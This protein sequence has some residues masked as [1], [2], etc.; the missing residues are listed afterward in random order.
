LL[1]GI[2]GALALV[3]FPCLAVLINRL[4]E[5]PLPPAGIAAMMLLTPLMM[6][7]VHG[8]TMAKFDPL[9]ATGELPVYIAV[10][11]MTNGGF[12][13]A[14]LV[15]ALATSALTWLIT[16]FGMGLVV[17]LFGTGTAFSKVDTTSP[18]GLGA[19]LIGCVPIFLLLVI[20]TWKNLI[21]GMGAGLTGRPWVVKLFTALSGASGMG[22]FVL[23]AYA[24]INPDFQAA[25]IHWLPGVLFVSLVVKLAVSTVAFVLGLRRKAITPAAIAWMGGGWLMSGVFLGGYAALICGAIHKTDLWISAALTA[26]LVLP[27][28]RLAIAPLALAWNRHR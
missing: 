11:P 23:I 18:Y 22:L 1:P 20:L 9:D 25:L 7:G 26:F 8:T 6:S 28:A 19:L 17:L 10:R 4:G 24:K 14:K 16:V 3:V 27:L 15:M 2:T 12:V 21:A 5:S 13:L